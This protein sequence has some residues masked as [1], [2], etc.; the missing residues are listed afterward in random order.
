MELEYKDVYHLKTCLE[1]LDTKGLSEISHTT[2]LKAFLG[3]PLMLYWPNS[4]TPTPWLA[5][6]LSASPLNRG[7]SQSPPYF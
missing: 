3:L 5:Q 6:L 7:D 2:N 1:V 4:T